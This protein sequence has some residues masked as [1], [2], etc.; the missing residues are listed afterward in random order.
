M[1][2]KNT[3]HTGSQVMFYIF[4][5]SGQLIITFNP[6]EELEKLIQVWSFWF[7]FQNI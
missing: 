2:I 7:Y 6:K 3:F 1:K 4:K 5:Y